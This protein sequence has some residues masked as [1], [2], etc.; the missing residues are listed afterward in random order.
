MSSFDFEVENQFGI[1]S[2]KSRIVY[3]KVG[4]GG[5]I[6]GYKNRYVDIAE[7]IKN[8]YGY[9]VV[10]SSNP[11]E[12]ACDLEAE[13]SKILAANPTTEEIIFVGHSNGASVGAQQGYRV[14]RIKSMLLINGPLMINWHW[15]KRGCEKFTGNRIHFVYGTKDPSAKYAE[16]VDLIENSNCT[17]ELLEGVD[18]DFAGREEDFRK[19]IINFVGEN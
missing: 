3:I 2:G 6:Y 13:I 10:V 5:S 17:Y 16:M 9:A 11:L 7:E 19:L 15:I 8:K 18:H 4:R 1:M 12:E 14:S